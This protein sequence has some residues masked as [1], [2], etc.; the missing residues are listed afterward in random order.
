[1][2]AGFQPQPQQ[3]WQYKALLH[4]VSSPAAKNVVFNKVNME[5]DHI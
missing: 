2:E 1:M 5:T 3:H 4:E